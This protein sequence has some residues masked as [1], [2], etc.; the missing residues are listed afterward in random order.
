MADTLAWMV[1][2]PHPSVIGSCRGC[3]PS[4]QNLRWQFAGSCTGWVI[5]IACTFQYCQDA[6]ILYS[7]REKRSC[8]YTVVFGTAIGAKTGAG[9]Q[10]RAASSGGANLRAI[11]SAIDKTF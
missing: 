5:D 3:G 2:Q 8:L 4:I 1:I 7:P 6:P 9:S 11:R 10:N